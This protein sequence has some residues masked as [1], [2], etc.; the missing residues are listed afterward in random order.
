VK[1]DPVNWVR[2]GAPPRS[3]TTTRKATAPTP[4]AAPTKRA[5]LRLTEI[6]FDCTLLNYGPVKPL[7]VRAIISTRPGARPGPDET[8]HAGRQQVWSKERKTPFEKVAVEAQALRRVTI[9]LAARLRHVLRGSGRLLPRGATRERCGMATWTM[10][11]YVARDE[12]DGDIALAREKAKEMVKGYLGIDREPDD[13][14]IISEPDG[15]RFTWKS[16][17]QS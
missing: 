8:T 16:E 11:I 1:S 12:T 17:G 15:W 13:W 14:D 9:P 7:S 10:D 3:D 4:K 2:D 5:D 6:A